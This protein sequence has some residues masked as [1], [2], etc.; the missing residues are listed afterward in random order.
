MI[1]GV[2]EIRQ[3]VDLGADVHGKNNSNETPCTILQKAI[4]AQEQLVHKIIKNEPSEETGISVIQQIVI[5]AVGDPQIQ[6][7][8]ADI[9]KTKPLFPI[10]LERVKN[11][12]KYLEA[13]HSFNQFLTTFKK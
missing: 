2:T 3:L 7:E 12:K 10:Y 1:K 13:L 6:Q 5:D 8:N 9:I 11:E 4:A